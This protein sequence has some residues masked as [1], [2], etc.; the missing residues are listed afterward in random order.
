MSILEKA[1]D[2]QQS[3]LNDEHPS[4]EVH[5]DSTTDK[6]LNLEKEY[7]FNFESEFEELEIAAA[8]LKQ[9]R[10]FFQRLLNLEY[11]LNF[12]NKKYMAYL[13][14]FIASIA[15]LLSGVDQSIIS[16]AQ[17]TMRETLQLSDDQMSLVISLMPLGA[18][19]GSIL[20]TPMNEYVGRRATI[21]ISCIW[22][23]VGAGLAA[24]A[25]SHHM[26]YAARFLIGVGVGLEGASVGVYISECSPPHLRGNL[27]SLYQFN[28]AL[29][30]VLGYAIAAIFYDV[31]G[32]W[33]FMVG[34]SLVFS[35]LLLVGL[36]FVPE[37][38][39]FLVH[40]GNNAAAYL[41]WKR[42][43]DMNEKESQLEFLE[44]K[45]AATEERERSANESTLKSFT[46]LFRYARN[47]R[48]LVYS[49]VMI[50]LGQLT[51][52][53][54]VM[55]NLSTL[56]SKVGFSTKNAVFMSLV[57]GG[58]LLVGTIPAI[59]WMDKYG[60]RTWGMNIVGFFIGLVLVGAAYALDLD[61]HLK[62]VEGL[63]FTGLVLYMGFFGS[64]ACLT[65]VV[66][67]ESFDLKTRSIGMTIASAFLYLWNF[68]VTYCFTKMKN[69]FTLTGLTLGFYGGIAFLGII[70]QFLFMPETKGKTLEEIDDIF[71]KSSFIIAKENI[72]N[73]NNWIT[74]KRN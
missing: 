10:N 70:Y 38:P 42:L 16:G 48:A 27:V 60:R 15:G 18:V 28:I 46:E 24:G 69:A 19:L 74:K 35:T 59:L 20:M 4:I 52:V 68:T 12:Q 44:M 37:S 73:F 9:N 40:K 58:S 64:Y 65:W 55:S 26:M 13:V 17:I 66:P 21:I 62:T 45:Q 53:N 67:A 49:V 36:F 6:I 1:E 34:S 29:G 33:R 5:N 43:R 14:G 22:Y 54:A 2:S 56:I 63:Y 30:E 23:T 72:R 7:N 8:N 47:R 31:H 41:V 51:G 11:E 39:R 57:G 71:S 50:S 25:R 32:G 3:I 61:T